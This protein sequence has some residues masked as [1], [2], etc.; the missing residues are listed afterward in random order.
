MIRLS[1]PM[2]GSPFYRDSLRIKNGA[3]IEF[4]TVVVQII[5]YLLSRWITR[6]VGSEF[7]KGQ[8]GDAFVGMQMQALVVVT[9]GCACR[10]CLF[11]DYIF[12]VPFLQAGSTGQ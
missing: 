10:V 5:D 3:D 1:G 6:Y 7:F 8:V 4:F 11:N 12:N 2:T 9:P